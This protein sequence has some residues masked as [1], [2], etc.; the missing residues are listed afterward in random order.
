MKINNYDPLVELIQE[1]IKESKIRIV[2][3]SLIIVLLFICIIW[4]I[5]VFII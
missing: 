2:I 5:A 3:Y 4:Y 1:E